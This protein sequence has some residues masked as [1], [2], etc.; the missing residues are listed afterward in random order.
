MLAWNGKKT[1]RIQTSSRFILPV[2]SQQT[3]SSRNMAG[4]MRFGRYAI[5]Q[6]E[7]QLIGGVVSHLIKPSSV[8]V[9]KRSVWRK[10]EAS[11]LVQLMLLTFWLLS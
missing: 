1:V 9:W 5:E 7:K 8:L 4:A 10:P 6:I 3:S 2:G 11:S